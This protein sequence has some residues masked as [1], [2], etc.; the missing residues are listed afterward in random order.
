ML[1]MTFSP[2]GNTCIILP[3]LYSPVLQASAFLSEYN[4]IRRGGKPSH[5]KDKATDLSP[6]EVG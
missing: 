1:C 4:L 5:S 2:I 6:E 3:K